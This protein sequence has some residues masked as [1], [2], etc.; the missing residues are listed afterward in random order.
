M[1]QVQSSMFPLFDLN[2]QNY[3]ENIY[4]AEKEDF[5]KAEHTVYGSSRILL[6]VVKSE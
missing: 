5:E 2:P 1:I 6:P 4:E 3:V